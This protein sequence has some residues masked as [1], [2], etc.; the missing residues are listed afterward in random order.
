VSAPVL[1][2][3]PQHIATLRENVG[4]I[5]RLLAIHQQV[6]GAGPGYKHD[7]EVL[8][9]SAIV[10]LVACWEAFVE[11]LARLAFL[12]LLEQSAECT[13]FPPK[14]L[15][16]AGRDL[17]ADLNET[18]IWELAGGGWKTVL[19]NHQTQVFKRFLG[20]FNTPRPGQVD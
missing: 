20:N 1:P 10:L 12:F 3:V 11:D 7:V 15:A 19:R 18:R 5:R 16:L 4:D 2:T 8:N 13:T 9:K 14:V 17:R 6:S